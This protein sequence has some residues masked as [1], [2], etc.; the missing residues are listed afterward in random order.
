VHKADVEKATEVQQHL[1]KVAV[2]NVR[3]APGPHLI[4]RDCNIY[5][6]I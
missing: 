2:G 4:R 3:L 1:G 5:I 6:Y